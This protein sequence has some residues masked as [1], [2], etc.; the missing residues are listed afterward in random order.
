MKISFLL[1]GI[2]LN[3][4]IAYSQ[5]KVFKA[6]EKGDIQ[7]LTDY[8]KGGKDLN[9]LSKASAVD[10]YNKKKI[11]YSFDLLEYAA[12]NQ[13]MDIVKLLLNNKDKIKNFPRS[14]NKAFAASI[15]NGSMEMVKLFIENGA[16]INAVCEVCYQQ[17]A[18]HTAL[19]YS[20]FDICNYLLEKDADINVH[21][22]FG[23]TLMHS[24]AHTGNVEIAKLLIDKGLDINA[25]DNDGAT[26]LIYA[27]SN[28]D[29]KMFKL[30][31]DR[32][33]E[34]SIKENDG[35]DVLM[36]AVEDGNLDIVSFLL[37]KCCDINLRNNDDE[38]AIIFAAELK[39]PQVVKLLIAKGA[40]LNLV[41]N[42]GESALLWAIW[43]SDVETA[44]LII[45]KGADLTIMDYL[46]PAKR[47][48]KDQSFIDYLKS[49][50]KEN[51]K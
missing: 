24:V 11:Y 15:S 13:K 22:S 41:N 46:K 12:I 10:E 45:D 35:S 20:Y 38:T 26:P 14:L 29:Y 9:V 50:I 2:T 8:I 47:Y 34:L 16:D 49:K 42:K 17:T 19:E 1:I 27:A 43:N 28:G 6:I 18:I 40:N 23:R 39:K 21:N 31:V 33:A 30:L 25:Q 44:K 37:D 48:I 5:G 32:G 7:Y 36:S 3:V 51:E 4:S